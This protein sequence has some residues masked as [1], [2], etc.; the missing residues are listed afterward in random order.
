MSTV[1]TERGKLLQ[2][3]ISPVE[4]AML[5]KLAGNAGL[6][7]SDIARLLIREAYA[8]KYGTFEACAA[9]LPDGRACGEPAMHAD[10]RRLG[11]PSVCEEHTKM[12]VPQAERVKRS[13]ARLGRS[14]CRVRLRGASSG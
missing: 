7:S 1:A 8:Q 14:T 4:L 13:G 10:S 3:R 5:A 9:L 11:G 2:I 6:S 12:P